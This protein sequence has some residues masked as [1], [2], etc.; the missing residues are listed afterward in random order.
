MIV[1]SVA[2]D[3]VF[4]SLI[5][6]FE[7]FRGGTP[8]DSMVDCDGRRIFYDHHNIENQVVRGYVHSEHYGD[9]YWQTRSDGKFNPSKLD[10]YYLRGLNVELKSDIK[11]GVNG[12]YYPGWTEQCRGVLIIVQNYGSGKKLVVTDSIG[13]EHTLTTVNKYNWV[14]NLTPGFTEWK[15]VNSSTN[16]IL[17]SGSFRV[18]G[19]I[20]MLKLNHVANC[21][22][23]GGWPIVDK[24]NVKTGHIKYGKILRGRTL[25]GEGQTVDI[26]GDISTL[27]SEM[28][29]NMHIDLNTST[30]P[31]M[32]ND[33]IFHTM[34]TSTIMGGYKGFFASSSKAAMKNI[35]GWLAGHLPTNGNCAY[36]N[37][38]DGKDRTGCVC[39]T[40]EALCGCS[41]DSIIK[42]WESTTFWS[43]KS[44]VTIDWPYKSGDYGNWLRDWFSKMYSDY[45]GSNI[46]EMAYNYLKTG[47]GASESDINSVKNA[48][49]EIYP[50]ADPADVDVVKCNESQLGQYNV[51]DDIFEARK[52]MVVGS[53]NGKVVYNTKYNACCTGYIDV[54]G[55]SKIKI[56]NAFAGPAVA[57]YDATFNFLG[58]KSV[59][60]GEKT[61][62]ITAGAKYVVVN[63]AYDR[64]VTIT[65]N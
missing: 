3:N 2:N 50:I 5:Q 14:Y 8:I 60:S 64:P 61:I 49:S 47:C 1:C 59:T 65:F 34:T 36:I 12:R 52:Y 29:V 21:R 27:K 20:R 16:A 62:S 28:G 38:T 18:N 46:S 42:D 63:F 10:D 7:P 58:G 4:D 22:D 57:F 43:F 25:M 33:V 35:V 24:N 17:D 56:S 11:K 48:L 23:I 40:L 15:V 44:F 55:K 13:K 53:T 45:S 19:Q 54:T 6:T 41:E 51:D 26:S 37:C 32:G 31:T 30:A 9:K 39:A